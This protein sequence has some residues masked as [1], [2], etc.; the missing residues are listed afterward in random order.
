MSATPCPRLFEADPRNQELRNEYAGVCIRGDQVDTAIKLIENGD[1]IDE[2]GRRLLIAAYMK[3]KN[4]PKANQEVA[5]LA[6]ETKAL[7]TSER[8][9]MHAE[10]GVPD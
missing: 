7:K 1:V 3:Q 10:S 6:L 9:V 4:Y 2:K 5:K 8:K